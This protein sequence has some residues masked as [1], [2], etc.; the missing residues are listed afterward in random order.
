MRPLPGSA[1]TGDLLLLP[2]LQIE[3]G[4]ISKQ[5]VQLI[6]PSGAGLVQYLGNVTMHYT[7]IPFPAPLFSVITKQQGVWGPALRS[8][9]A[10][11][12]RET[13]VRGLQN[14]LERQMAHTRSCCAD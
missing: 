14:V 13:P 9:S 6:G 1:E 2:P 12:V 8:F 3:E 4:R 7:Y 11:A 10:A 5:L